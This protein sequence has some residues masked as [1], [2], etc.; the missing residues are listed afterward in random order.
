MRK[1]G[2]M[3]SPAIGRDEVIRAA[4][5]HKVLKD[6]PAIVGESMA[7]RSCPDRYDHG[8]LWIAVEGSAWAQELRMQK[9][10]I[11]QKLEEKA[12]EHGLFTNLRFG[13]RPLKDAPDTPTEKRPNTP[14]K[15]QDGLSIQDIAEARLRNWPDG[16]SSS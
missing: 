8:V 12:K 1:V 4:R 9:D 10:Q 7:A 14:R 16:R 2:H 15:D 13:V 5:A 11:L 3:L 6:W